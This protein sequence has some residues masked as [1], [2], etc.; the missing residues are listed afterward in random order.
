MGHEFLD[1]AT[2]SCS[3][4]LYEVVKIICSCHS[5]LVSILLLFVSQPFSKE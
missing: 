1:S 5:S 4:W 2:E 3:L